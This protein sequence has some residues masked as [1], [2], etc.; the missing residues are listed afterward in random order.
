MKAKTDQTQRKPSEKLPS[1][2]PRKPQRSLRTI[3]IVWF[4]LFALV[5]LAFVTGY[6][7]IKFEKAIDNELSRRLMGNAREIS[8]IF[9]DF[10]T[11]LEAKRDRYIKDPRLISHLTFGD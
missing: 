3:L 10:Q 1:R 2:P 7:V 8:S 9:S 5:P 11:N 6:S 4:L